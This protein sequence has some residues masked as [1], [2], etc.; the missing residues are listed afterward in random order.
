MHTMKFKK[1]KSHTSWEQLNKEVITHN[2]EFKRKTSIDHMVGTE[3]KIWQRNNKYSDK[4]LK[5]LIFT[6]IIKATMDI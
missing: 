5:Y 6:N 1:L 3:K 4:H 2:T